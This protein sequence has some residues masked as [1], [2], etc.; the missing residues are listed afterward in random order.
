MN[1]WKRLI[2]KREATVQRPRTPQEQRAHLERTLKKQGLPPQEIKARLAQW[3]AH[4]KEYG[5]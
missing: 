4:R 5:R 3:D 2:G 1:F